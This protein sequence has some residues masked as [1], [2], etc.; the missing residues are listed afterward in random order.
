ML[1]LILS[2]IIFYQKLDL[3]SVITVMCWLLDC[4]FFLSGSESDWTPVIFE[5]VLVSGTAAVEKYW[6]TPSAVSTTT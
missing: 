6:S 5:P 2:L 1:I 4:S 3:I